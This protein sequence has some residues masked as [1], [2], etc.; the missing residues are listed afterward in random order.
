MELPLGSRSFR[1]NSRSGNALAYYSRPRTSSAVRRFSYGY[2]ALNRLTTASESVTGLPSG[3]AQG[4]WSWTFGADQYGNLWGTNT[5]GMSALMPPSSTYFDSAT[6]RLSKYGASP[7]TALPSDA[8]DAAGNLQNHPELCQN[9]GGACMQ[10]DGEGRLTQ[11]TNGGNVAHYDYDGEGRRVRKTETGSSPVTTVYVHDAGGVGRLASVTDIGLALFGIFGA[12]GG[13]HSDLSSIAWTPSQTTMYFESSLGGEGGDIDP[14]L[15]PLLGLG[16]QASG[17]RPPSGY[18]A[19]P[20]VPFVITGIG[21]LPQANGRGA[22]TGRAPAP[23]QVAIEPSNFGIPYDTKAQREAAMR[24][25]V[26]AVI[27]RIKIYPNFNTN[28]APLPKGTPQTPRGLPSRGPYSPV[29]TISPRPS[30]N[31][32]DLYRYG[33]MRNANA[34]T[35]ITR[36][37]IF[38]P[39]NNVG[40]RCPQ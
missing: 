18:Q 2:D 11:V 28:T 4:S 31:A 29:D 5:M 17:P 19:C 33:S 23:G 3:V 9:G 1:G 30:G 27:R 40:V 26:S 22:F 39:I 32:I 12:G 15:L 10:Y 38:I 34:S 14:D 36:P 25:P 21:P 35:R 7:G 6:N 20:S 16:F 13:S 8:Y 24:R 37:T